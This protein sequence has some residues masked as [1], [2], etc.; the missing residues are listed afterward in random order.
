MRETTVTVDGKEMPSHDATQR[1]RYLEREIRKQK[2]EL[3]TG[4]DGAKGKLA[5][6]LM[7]ITSAAFRTA[8]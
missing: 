1:Q 4:M 5:A 8:G 2:L 3:L 6:G 7:G